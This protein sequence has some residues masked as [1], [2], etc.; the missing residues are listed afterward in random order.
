MERLFP[1]QEIGSLSKPPWLVAAPSRGGATAEEVVHAES[2]GRL[3]DVEG[4]S[5]LL[6]TLRGDSLKGKKAELRDWA[7]LYVL[8]LFERV[9]LDYVYD[10]EQ[11]RIEM[12]EYPIRRTSG[13]EFLG[14][15]RSFDNKYYRKAACVDA[16]RFKK[17]YHMDEYSFVK[18][19][20]VK[21]VKVPITG[22]YTLADWSFNEYY[23]KR[24]ADVS[25]MK[26]RKLAAKRDLVLDLAEQVLR[27]NIEALVDAGARVVQL[28]EPA[29]TTHPEEVP[30]FVEGINSATEGVNCKFIVHVCYSDYRLL[31]PDV[32][33]MRCDQFAWEFANRDDEHGDG[34]VP[35][36]LF[37]EYDDGREIG[38]GVVDVH[39]NEVE[40]AELVRDRIVAAADAVGD[41]GR[42]Y[43]NPDCGLRT[44][45]WQTAYEKLTSMVK[46]AEMARSEF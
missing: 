39:V 6:K 43:V 40:T 28:D 35:L 4:H 13:F 11:R 15:A 14:H 36:E 16:T 42:V 17:A 27:P 22:P 7:S 18:E 9:G 45:T 21:Q 24:R 3:L 31:Y 26:Q 37:R 46:G 20:A 38:L 41:P 19:R 44:R 25:S 30:I 2:W 10:G 23:Q 1:C 8:R 5:D 32:L 34:Y 29:A 33:E 12:Y